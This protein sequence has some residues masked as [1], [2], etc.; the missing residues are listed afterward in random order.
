MTQTRKQQLMSAKHWFLVLAP[1]IVI[2]LLNAWAAAFLE[3]VIYPRVEVNGENVSGLTRQQAV[4]LL[5]SKPLGQTVKIKVA[6]KEFVATHEQ[7]GARYD[8]PATV[9][10]AYQVGR[11]QNIALAGLVMS[12]LKSTDIGFAHEV[13]YAR[14]SKFT[15]TV[16]ESI[17]QP[18]KNAAVVVTAGEVTVSE[19]APGI[20]LN[21]STITRLL[22]E[23]MSA[24][25][26]AQFELE[27]ESVD[28]PI[29]VEEVSTVKTQVEQLLK[30]Q[31]VL[32]YAGRE[33]RPAP[34][35]IGY[36]L[37]T[38]PDDELNPQRLV[39]RV[40]EQQIK[41]YVQSI[42]N[43]IN[44]NPVNKK[45]VV[46]NGVSS[47]DREGK[48]GLALDQ[49]AA[50][51]AI[52]EAM[53]RESG[54]PASIALVTNPIPFKTDTVRTTS[55]DAAKY[56]EVNISR[57]YLWAYENGQVVHS[58]PITTG[59]AGAGFPTV[60]GLFAIYYK[61]RNTYLNGRPY[62]YNYNVFVQY[63]MPFYSGYGLHDAS[64]R[65]AFGGQDYYYGGSHGCVNL[66]FG[67][68]AFIYNWAEVGT[69]VW[70][71]Q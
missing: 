3:G 55:L 18:A 28:A 71:H 40:D 26:D 62:G 64:W 13:D 10:L 2:L 41:G 56:I 8:I 30:R 17:G 53:E 4:S 57:Q 9:E 29:Q 58:A 39:V 1:L 11:D 32:T 65:S 27:P 45:V 68:A 36:W 22:T 61:A 6:G 7:V 63:W 23:S 19:D 34:T 49:E 70:V 33:Y 59:A 67:T 20:G 51:R 35:N 47:V 25:Q 43:D 15:D 44:Q 37:K 48:D 14:L 69:P 46:K 12:Q 31:I 52:R 24:A 60:T 42:A 66:P 54:S 16:V 21:R 5:Q 38:I 50:T